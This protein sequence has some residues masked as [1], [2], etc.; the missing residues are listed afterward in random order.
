MTIGI[1]GNEANN[2]F[3]VGIGQ[4]A[5]QVLCQLHKN[6]NDKL[7]FKIYLKDKPN[8]QLPHETSRW[9]YH[10][11]MPKKFWTQFALPLKL[12]RE[13]FI[14]QVPDVFFS[15]TH[16][17][18]RFCPIPS[19]ISIMDLSF[20]RYPELFTKKDLWQLK[21]WT[22]VSARKA[23]KILTISNFSKREIID[24]YRF[25]E[26]KVIVTYPGYDEKKFKIQ[27]SQPEAGP[28]LAEKF[29]INIITEKYNI[30]GDYIL[31]VGTLQPRKN[32][33]RLIETFN[34]LK[35][36]NLSLIIAGKKGWMYE[37]IFNKVKELELEKRIIFIDYIDEDELPDLYRKARCLVLPS[38][39]E[40]FGLP[41]VE[42]MACG[43]PVV[44]SDNTS[45]SEII[46]EAGILVNPLNI[47]DIARG[48]TLVSDNE[49]IR[50]TLIEKGLNRVKRFSW[51]SCA[52]RTLEVIKNINN[53]II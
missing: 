10:V 40:G 49:S 28:P 1:D 15:P 35:D 25:P 39:Y 20:I 52:G 11:I 7:K 16:Y 30:K 50:N 26:D 51:T 47:L 46:G 29:K 3:K 8:N 44:A 41:V 21:T 53:D 27:K 6:Q 2:T 17:A 23:S 37:D 9:K 33:I 48:I 31:F 42:A 18:P 5:F 45:L 14:G 43:C 13:K 22:A 32:I 34:T 19:V 24:Y 38:L 36:K 4:Y 12:W